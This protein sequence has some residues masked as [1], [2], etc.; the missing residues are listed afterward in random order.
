MF[1]SVSSWAGP[2]CDGAK[3]CAKL[4]IKVVEQVVNPVNYVIAAK[5]DLNAT[6]RLIADVQKLSFDVYKV[7]YV[8]EKVKVKKTHI[9]GYYRE[10]D[11]IQIETVLKRRSRKRWLEDD[12]TPDAWK[13]RWAVINQFK[14]KGEFGYPERCPSS[15]TPKKNKKFSD[16]CEFLIETKSGLR[17][18]KN[19]RHSS[20]GDIV[21]TRINNTY[22]VFSYFRKLRKEDASEIAKVFDALTVFNKKELKKQQVSHLSILR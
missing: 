3:E 2:I 19:S 14:V 15:Y 1:C 6:K 16:K 11:D 20:Y 9:A 22:I 21:Y 4:Q 17:L 5:G 10:L 13:K 18:Y 12:Y 8:P 7:N